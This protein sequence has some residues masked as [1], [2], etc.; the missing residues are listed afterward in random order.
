MAMRPNTFNLYM[1]VIRQWHEGEKV[2][3]I[4]NF[5]AITPQYVYVIASLMRKTLGNKIVPYRIRTKQS[6]IILMDEYTK[7]VDIINKV[8]SS[9]INKIAA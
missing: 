1:N 9:L 2:K 3:N 6:N 4:A 5:Q 8:H 7:A